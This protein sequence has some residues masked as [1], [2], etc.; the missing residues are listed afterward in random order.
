MRQRD[1]WPE[2]DSI[3]SLVRYGRDEAS[4]LFAAG[5]VA[6]GATLV[7]RAMHTTED[8]YLACESPIERAMFM[9]LVAAGINRCDGVTMVGPS[10]P[11]TIGD[12][13]GPDQ[14]RIEPQARLGRYRVDF[15]VTASA[16][17]A[18]RRGGGTAEA[19]FVVECDGH[20][21]HERT[22][23]QAKRDRKRDRALQAAGFRVYRYTGSEIWA[24]VGACAHEAVA[25]VS[26]EAWS[27]AQA[28]F[29]ARGSE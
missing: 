15:L 4:E 11:Q 14:M 29:E 6:T 28:D 27:R 5:M 1:S 17:W 12:P 3:S 16:A 10:G 9:G 7:V 22:R 20:D 26:A 18:G 21:F 23:E 24:D 25:A 2:V 8:A 13:A 19:T